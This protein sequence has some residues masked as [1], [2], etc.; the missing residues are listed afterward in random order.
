MQLKRDL[1]KTFVIHILVVFLLCYCYQG[2]FLFIYPPLLL[3]W[4]LQCFI[5][6]SSHILIH[7][8]LKKHF[9]KEDLIAQIWL[10]PLVFIGI[11]TALTFGLLTICIWMNRADF[12]RQLFQLSSDLFSKFLYIHFLL[13]FFSGTYIFVEL[14]LHWSPRIQRYHFSEMNRR[15]TRKAYLVLSVSLV[16]GLLYIVNF[17]PSNIVYIGAVIS[18]NLEDQT[19]K[20]INLFSSIPQEE[21]NLYLNSC[22]RIARLYQNQLRQYDKAIEY[23]NKI[24]ENQNSPLRDDAIYQSLICMF[25]S[26]AS[27]QEMTSYLQSKKLEQSCLQDEALFLIAK[28][29]EATGNFQQ[30]I[31]LYERLSKE[32][33]YS[34]TLL[35]FQNSRRPEFRLTRSL[36]RELLLEVITRKS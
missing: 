16:G 33:I 28:K 14:F 35:M 24:I 30:A 4:V 15:L 36:A 17:K 22:F 12:V 31:E 34:F 1:L 7:N 27:V 21:P 20:A 25:L 23:F 6:S 13:I 3:C 5:Y 32:S 18:S 19:E 29:W 26:K 8:K 2:V 11:Y 10:N 9:F